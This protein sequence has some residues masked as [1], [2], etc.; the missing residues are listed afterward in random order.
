VA[1]SIIGE[2]I[3]V[4]AENKKLGYASVLYS[5]LDSNFNEFLRNVYLLILLFLL[6]LQNIQF[7]PRYISLYWSNPDIAPSSLSVHDVGEQKFHITQYFDFPPLSIHC[8]ARYI[9][10]NCS[11]H[12]TGAILYVYTVYCC[13]G[14]QWKEIQHKMVTCDH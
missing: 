14:M 8:Q 2:I 6:L 1:S 3:I 11:G 9:A 10:T 5:V 4:Q 12:V 13:L 7:L